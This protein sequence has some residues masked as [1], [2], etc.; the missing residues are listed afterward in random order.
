MENIDKKNNIIDELSSIVE[1]EYDP[2]KCKK[3]NH[4]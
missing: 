4:F 3:V 2:E 1:K